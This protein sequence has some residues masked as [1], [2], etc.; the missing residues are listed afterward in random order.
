MEAR[1]GTVIG[2]EIELKTPDDF[3]KIRE[4]LSRIGIQSKTSRTLYQSCH[5]LHKRGLYYICT[6]K[7]LFLLDGKQAEISED[8]YRRRN[9]IAKL[10]STWGLC[11][12]INKKDIEFLAEP[13]EIKIVP[14]KEK[15]DWMLIAKYTIGKK[16]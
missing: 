7:E 2:V 10:I 11:S 16:R 14:Y 9:S 8:D 12:I 3:L 4:T 13:G 1:D 15:K 6:F 5:I